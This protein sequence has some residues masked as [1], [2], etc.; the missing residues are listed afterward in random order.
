MK[1]YICSHL[2]PEY[3][4]RDNRLVQICVGR[5]ADACSD[6]F[7]TDNT[8]ININYKNAQY[9]ELTALYWIWKNDDSKIKGLFHYSRF[10]DFRCANFTQH[11]TNIF[12]H[13]NGTNEL[14]LSNSYDLNIVNSYDLIL[15]KPINLSYKRFMN[16]RE[17]FLSNNNHDPEVYHIAEHVIKN[18]YSEY[19]NYFYEMSS[20]NY[21]YSCNILIA[22]GEIFNDYCK[23]LFDVL[24]AIES[25]YGTPKKNRQLGYIGERLLQVYFMHKI[26]THNIRYTCMDLIKIDSNF[27]VKKTLNKSS[28]RKLIKNRLR[29]L[30]GHK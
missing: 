17:D 12:S 8:S 4:I 1:L 28:M 29:A 25:H 27:K 10:L 3:V 23:W 2:R 14:S 24:G 13:I 9:S 7:I 19:L 18:S 11:K 15:P 30:L 22:K 21:F 20:S 5:E 16:N 26:R 6:E